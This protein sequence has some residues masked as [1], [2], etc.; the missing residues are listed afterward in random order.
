M[1]DDASFWMQAQWGARV[2]TPDAL[3]ER[4]LRTTAA[5][6]RLRAQFDDWDW[7]DAQ[8]IWDTEGQGG[9][10]PFVDVRAHLVHAIERNAG[11]GDEGTPDPF[12]GYL[13]AIKTKSDVGLTISASK[14]AKG[15]YAFTPFVNSAKFELP[16]R[17]VPSLLSFDLLRAV[18]LTVDE[19]WETTWAEASPPDVRPFWTGYPVRVAWMS[20]VSP[21]FASRMTPP[22]S[23]VVEHRPNGGL[24]LAATRDVFE[25]ANP[26]HLAVAREIEAA[27]QPLNRVPNPNDAPYL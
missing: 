21:H 7:G 14:G 16:P 10:Y 15:G 2:E 25:T 17:P 8:E 24:F 11:T 12:N 1:I 27:L 4:L 5:L 26:A 13:M 20:Y 19:I 6:Q 9:A 3:A 23:A 22:A 18:F